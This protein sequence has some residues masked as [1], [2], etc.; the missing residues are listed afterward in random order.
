M[1]ASQKGHAPIVKLLLD[2]K[3]DV[4]AARKTDG[5]TSLMMASQNG[6]TEIVKLL[7]DAK[8]DVLAIAILAG[9]EYTP[10]DVAKKQGHTAVVRLLESVMPGPAEAEAEERH[11]KAAMANGP[12]A[13]NRLGLWYSEGKRVKQDLAE[14]VRWYRKAADLG[15]VTAMHNLADAYRRGL[16]VT[17]DEAEADKWTR[18]AEAASRKPT[19]QKATP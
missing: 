19:T 9:R 5:G 13:M 16:G 17:K 4:N 7:L 8:A 15:Y 6:H 18:M 14:A 1:A 10:L 2:A 12:A 3:A 11:C